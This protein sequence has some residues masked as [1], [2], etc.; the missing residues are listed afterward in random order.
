LCYY[1]KG[2]ND[3]TIRRGCQTVINKEE[4][5]YIDK[6]KRRKCEPGE[7]IRIIGSGFGETQG[8]SVVHI[9]KR[10]YDSDSRRIKTW[11]DT[12]IRIK[13]P[14]YR[15][16]WFDG[17]DYRKEKVWV[18]VDGVDSNKNRLKVMKPAT[19]E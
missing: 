18:T 6:L 19:C 17:Q 10:T 16:T 9:G 14:K 13:V 11:S 12:K 15:C 4:E 1:G 5:P 3:P 7:K 8:D 2:L